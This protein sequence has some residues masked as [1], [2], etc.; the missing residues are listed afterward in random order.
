MSSRAQSLRAKIDGS[1]NRIWLTNFLKTLKNQNPVVK[2]R[3]DWVFKDRLFPAKRERFLTDSEHFCTTHFTGGFPCGLAIFQGDVL[4]IFPIPFG[5]ALNT[6]EVC[7]NFFHLP[8][9]YLSFKYSTNSRPTIISVKISVFKRS[10][11]MRLLL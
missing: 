8:S 5:A 3:G 2:G 10:F 4:N 9:S 1:F 7:H 6:I 11:L